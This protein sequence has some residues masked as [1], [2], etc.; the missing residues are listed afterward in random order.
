ME[1]DAALAAASVK[2]SSTETWATQLWR[3]YMG[4]LDGVLRKVISKLVE[5]RRLESARKK[6]VRAVRNNLRA[7]RRTWGVR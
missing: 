7:C 6:H 5:G 4:C 3:C 2:A 1:L